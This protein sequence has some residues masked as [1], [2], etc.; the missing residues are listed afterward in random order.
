VLLHRFLSAIVLVPAIALLAYLGGIAWFLAVCVVAVVA[1]R[2]VE[3]LLQSDRFQADRV[4][5]LII[6]LSLILEAY[7]TS[8]VR[9]DVELMRALMA[10]ILLG[11]LIWALYR[12]TEQPTADWS[13]TLAS[14]L[15]LGVLLGHFII[16]RKRSNGLAW[17]ML[18]FV[19]TWILDS[20]SYFI[21]NWLG[22]HKLWPRL[23]PR[24]TWEGL[25][26][27]TAVLVVV[28]PF[29]GMWWLQLEVWS[30]VVLAL[31][32]A[33]VAPFGDFA[34]S[35]FKRRA[36]VKDSSALIPGHGGLMDRLDS[37]LFVF[38][39]VTYFAY[40]VPGG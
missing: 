38:P 16:L 19:L 2:E 11:S 15:Y 7:L 20:M 9:L 13:V 23:S 40:F 26:G 37:L 4:L 28:A 12:T 22:K 18:A 34:V 8:A 17:V 5:A 31:L 24:K 39:V 33:I 35:L 10:V 29:L 3:R 32:V 25:I 1:W 36:Q 14:G 27:G 30:S 21:G 6:A